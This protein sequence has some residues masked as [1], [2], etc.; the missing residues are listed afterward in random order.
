MMEEFDKS[1][2]NSSSLCD[3]K[4]TLLNWISLSEK[5]SLKL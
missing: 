3:E 2:M 4:E 1:H 5:F